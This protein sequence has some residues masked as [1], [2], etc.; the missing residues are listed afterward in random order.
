MYLSRKTYTHHIVLGAVHG[1]RGD[2]PLLYFCILDFSF[3]LVGDTC[4]SPCA[5]YLQIKRSHTIAAMEQCC[6]SI[7]LSSISCLSVMYLSFYLCVWGV[8]REEW[9]ILFLLLKYW[10]NW[11]DLSNLYIVKHFQD[12]YTF[13]GYFGNPW[14]WVKPRN[15]N[16]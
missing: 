14:S 2:G 12:S 7:S 15:K 6:V 13:L 10:L 4:Q 9:A 11:I 5:K 16:N 1:S 8:D 3:V